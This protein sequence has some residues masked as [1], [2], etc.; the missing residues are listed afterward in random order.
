MSE[1]KDQ[2]LVTVLIALLANLGVGIAKLVAGLL[3]GS[4][5]LLS[6]AAH[7]M[8]DTSTQ[9]LLL[10]AVR[11]SQKPADRQYPFGYGKDR[12]FWSLLAAMGILVS[13]AAFSVY[14]GVRTIVEGG[15]QTA[16][17]WVNYLVLG[18]ALVLEGSSLF[19]ATRQVKNE[20]A[21]HRR[22]VPG[23][24]EGSDDP[25]PRAVLMED[26]AAVVGIVLAGGGVA[27]HQL[28]G[29]AI[30]DG[31]A[32]ILI[33]V[34]L[35]VVA[36]LLAGTSRRLL[37]GRQADGRMIRAIEQRLEQQPEVDDVVDLLTMMTGTDRVLLCARVDFVN[38]YSAGD[39]EQA[40]MRIDDELRKEFPDL[41]EIF[42]QPVPRSDQDL[43]DRVLRRYGHVFADE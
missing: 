10:T 17:V 35:A 30:W 42:I 43:R 7:S 23:Q 40:C 12:Y 14:E 21:E 27:L 15:E 20:A 26:S 31:I 8:G 36:V 1:K 16:Y 24:L 28:T 25:A 4:G 39:V 6:E 3:S 5:A 13:G 2:S 18:I 37:L 34:L 22:S 33:G 41:D 11:R 19:Q 38:T 32:S 9:V 29:Q